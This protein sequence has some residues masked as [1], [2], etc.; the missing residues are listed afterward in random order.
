MPEERYDEELEL[1]EE[2]RLGKLQAFTY[3]FL[4]PLIFTLLLATVL[5][6]ALGVID[7]GGTFSGIQAW[8]HELPVV[9]AW[10]PEP[11]DSVLSERERFLIEME[12]GFATLE[13]ERENLDQRTKDLN[14]R[15]E[16]FTEASRLLN[17][18]IATWESREK[19]V[20]DLVE[21]FEVMKA[22]EAG[23]IFDALMDDDEETAT[24]VVIRMDN[25]KASKILAAMDQ[26]KAARL[27]RLM[28]R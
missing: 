24:D 8:M 2:V 3:L 12:E 7:L 4:V 23:A 15:E 14:A 21:M 28:R 6:S 27:A 18:R 13:K 22:D 5:G 25:T 9:G 20:T 16:E 26:V 17:Q 19:R 10:I 1:E 11:D